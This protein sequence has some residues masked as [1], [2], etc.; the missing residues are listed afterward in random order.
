MNI[1]MHISFQIIVF[2]LFR[3]ISKSGIDGLYVV[4]F[5]IFWGNV[6]LFSIVALPV[7]VFINRKIGFPF[8]QIFANIAIYCF[9][10]NH[11]S[12][13]CEMIPLWFWFA[14]PWWLVI[15]RVLVGHLYVIFRNM[16]IQVLCPFLVALFVFWC[17]VVWV[18]KNIFWI[19]TPYQIC[20]I[21]ISSPFQ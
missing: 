7:C 20:H 16:F 3:K 21:Q 4:L 15:F 18:F 2:I 6:I 1:G 13:R 19:F 8:F 14:F 11:H 12:N 10:D 9:F 17:W 5:L